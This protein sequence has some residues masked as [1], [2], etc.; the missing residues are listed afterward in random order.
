M[1]VFMFTDIE[2]STR[3]WEQHPQAMGRV[4]ARHDAILQG[5][6]EE[7]GGSVIKHMGDG[8]FVVFEGGEPVRCAL[9][10]QKQLTQEDWG[11]IGPLRVRIALH[12]GDAEQRGGDYFGLVVNRTARIL[13]IG[14]GAQ[15][16]LTPEVV[17]AS[18]LP[19]QAS[20]QD[21]GVHW[22]RDLTEPQRIL[23]LVHPDLR[24]QGSSPLRVRS[25]CPGPVRQAA[26]ENM[27][28][29]KNTPGVPCRQV[30]NPVFQ[31]FFTDGDSCFR[32]L[33]PRFAPAGLSEAELTI[34]HS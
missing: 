29:R 3:L 10:I 4:L 28:A 20:L 17:Q 12:A 26:D 1:P 33:L 30:F 5:L 13:A 25:A 7:Y 22:F 31:P 15:I 11:T 27:L 6:V 21:R 24:W 16:L 2:G 34:R 14:W 19:A 18:G 9:E 23:E 8:M 32:E